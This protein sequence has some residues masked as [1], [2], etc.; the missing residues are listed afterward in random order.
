MD[1]LLD[2]FATAATDTKDASTL[3]QLLP[4]MD[5]EMSSVGSSLDTDELSGEGSEQTKSAYEKQRASLQSYLDSLPYE[6]ESVEEMQDKLEVIIGKILI[7]AKTQNW[8]LLST[9]DSILHWCAAT[10][11]I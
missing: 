11:S 3:A 2:T 7:C 6:C 5:E 9:W 8:L 10:Q 4:I 1:T